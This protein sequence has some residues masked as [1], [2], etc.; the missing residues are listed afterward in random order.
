MK[1]LP[2]EN[3]KLLLRLFYTNPEKS[4]FIQEIGRILGKK[5]GV[6]QR[7]LYSM[8]KEGLLKSNYQANARFFQA[9]TKH[10]L[11]PELEKIVAKTVGAPEA[12][13]HFFVGVNDA[14]LALIYGSFARGSERKDSDIDLLIVGKSKIE[15]EL[16]KGIP[17]IEK[18]FQR[19]INY[20]LYSEKE[21][22]EK[23]NEKEPFLEEVLS[24]KYILLKG[25]IH[26]V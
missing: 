4:F 16:L 18:S 12:L 5:P 10:P 2:S 7:T 14:K 9:N 11:Y 3:Q 22:R 24:G 20:K 17:A 8:E 21:F 15:E 6:F 1:T 26:D 13:R 23:K 25:D 19:E